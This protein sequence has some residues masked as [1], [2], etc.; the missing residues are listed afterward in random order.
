M[1]YDMTQNN[2]INFQPRNYR[3][4]KQQCRSKAYIYYYITSNKEFENI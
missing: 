3:E 1:W 4:I 2:L